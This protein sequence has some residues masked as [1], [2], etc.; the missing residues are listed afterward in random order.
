M[1]SFVAGHFGIIAD[2]CCQSSLHLTCWMW[3]AEATA[4]LHP[5]SPPGAPGTRGARRTTG[6]GA[7][8]CCSPPPTRRCAS[9]W[10]ICGGTAGRPG[11]G[12][13]TPALFA[14]IAAMQCCKICCLQIDWASFEIPLLG[15]LKLLLLQ[16]QSGNASPSTILTDRLIES[17]PKPICVACR[18]F[19]GVVPVSPKS[20]KSTQR[21]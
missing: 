4:G 21:Q 15:C 13:A 6:T 19:Q 20:N 7:S 5:G 8:L 2:Y 3:L 10:P 11:P 1:C 12:V 14:L 16:V 9:S 17:A 18:Q